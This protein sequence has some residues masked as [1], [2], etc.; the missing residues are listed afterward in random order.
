MRP[1]T[2][3]AIFWPLVIVAP[4]RAQVPAPP[5]AFPRAEVGRP[6][7]GVHQFGLGLGVDPELH[8]KRELLKV[9]GILDELHATDEQRTRL[10]AAEVEAEREAKQIYQKIQDEKGRLQRDGEPGADRVFR[11]QTLDDARRLT[12][13][14]ERPLLKILN[15][16]QVKR[17][18]QIQIRADG[19]E[20]FT[21][22]EVTDRLG[23]TPDQEAAIAACVK[24]GH[25]SARQAAAPY[26]QAS[27]ASSQLPEDQ[28]QARR[29]SEPF[30]ATA[31]R[32]RSSVIAARSTTLRAIR[33]ILTTAQQATF[34][35][36]AGPPFDFDQL[37]PVQRLKAATP[38]RDDPLSGGLL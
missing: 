5:I 25:A 1:L 28:G 26:R 32:A 9:P 10:K 23:L 4:G 35:N 17:L 20:A 21:V 24:A 13:D 37:D 38:G 31:S 7:V 34:R 8:S 36:L 16:K 30:L 12:R 29:A 22:A 27:T 18:E 33:D 2:W 11:Q 14:F 6:G 15:P 3:S 19:S